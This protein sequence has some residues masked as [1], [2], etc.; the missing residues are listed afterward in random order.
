MIQKKWY[1]FC[2]LLS[3]ALLHAQFSATDFH[4]LEQYYNLGSPNQEQPARDFLTKALIDC[5]EQ[6]RSGLNVKLFKTILYSEKGKSFYDPNMTDLETVQSLIAQ[7]AEINSRDPLNVPK[8][9]HKDTP[10]IFAIFLGKQHIANWLIDKG[11]NVNLTNASGWT[12][13][14]TAAN[15]GY[16]DVV[17]NLIRHKANPILRTT[18]EQFT[19][20]DMAAREELKAKEKGNKSEEQLFH[21]IAEDIREWTI[22]FN[23]ANTH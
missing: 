16:E 7:G 13:L 17:K 2:I 14:M 8:E 9:N 10:L 12:A 11:A 23:K 22:E 5:L 18:S 15:A 20:Q 4:S 19:A 21:T 6:K 1:P 3:N